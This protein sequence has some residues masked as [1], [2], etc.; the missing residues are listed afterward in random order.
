MTTRREKI[1]RVL[2]EEIAIVDYDPRWSQLFEEE[3]RHLLSCLPA[4]QVVRIEHFGSTAVPGL[5]AKPI[6]DMLVEVKNLAVARRRI[7]PILEAQGYDYFWRPSFGDIQSPYYAWFIKRD[8]QGRRTHHIHMIEKHFSQWDGL[9]FRDYLID[10]PDVARDYEEL[11]R[12]LS[13]AYPADR[14]AYTIAK[15]EFVRRV[16]EAAKRARRSW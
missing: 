10:H 5:A 9:L 14:A 4:D 13:R 12:R 16:T 6:V 3:K 2:Q 8:D 1:E 15:G 11:K 7:V